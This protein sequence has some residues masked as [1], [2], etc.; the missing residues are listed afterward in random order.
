MDNKRQF[1]L[2]AIFENNLC[3]ESGRDPPFVEL[4]NDILAKKNGADTFVSGS[5]LRGRDRS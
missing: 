3:E 4:G 1:E 5:L 2:R